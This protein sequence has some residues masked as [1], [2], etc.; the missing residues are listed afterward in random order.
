MAALVVRSCWLAM[1]S[2]H[3]R[4]RVARS[5]SPMSSWPGAVT[6][7]HPKTSRS[8]LPPEWSDGRWSLPTL[9]RL[10]VSPCPVYQGD[11]PADRC[12][13]V[14][15]LRVVPDFVHGKPALTHNLTC[16]RKLRS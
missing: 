14:G 12:A 10:C 5:G 6:G 8:C 9:H 1:G 3:P 7:G 2:L 16:Y 4:T 13:P 11:A 15:V